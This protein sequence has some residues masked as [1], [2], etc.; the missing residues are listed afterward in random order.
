MK[1][2]AFSLLTLIFFGCKTTTDEELKSD[3]VINKKVIESKVNAEHVFLTL[4][5]RVEVFKLIDENKITYNGD[6][7]N[8]P[9]DVKKYTN[10][11]YKGINLG[12]YGSDLNITNIFDQTQES[13]LF[14]ESV[15][16]LA[17]QVGVSDAFNKN[18]FERLDNN[19]GIKDSTLEIV[20]QAFKQ[21]DEILRRNDRASTS[22]LILCGAWIEGLYVACVIANEIKTENLVKAVTKQ[23]ESLQNLIV[24][25]EACELDEAS[26]F[27][28]VDLKKLKALFQAQ[29]ETGLNDIA[30]ISG[31]TNQITE[32]RTKLIS[33]K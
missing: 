14:L 2:F 22:A 4:P 21:S 32:I 5:D 24:M 28:V 17:T 18:M 27:L 3:E 23:Q 25:L 26:Q 1:Y 33:A 15:N 29:K 9:M 6:I 31:I 16:V 30:T 12:I 11:F 10:E 13:L 8:N 19:K 7:L 20:T